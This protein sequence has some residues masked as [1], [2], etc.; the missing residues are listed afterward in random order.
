MDRRHTLKWYNCEQ[1]WRTENETC[2]LFT[3][4][5]PAGKQA[6]GSQLCGSISLN[7]SGSIESVNHGFHI[8]NA[9]IPSLQIWLMSLS[10]HHIAHQLQLWIREGEW[11]QKHQPGTR[12]CSSLKHMVRMHILH[13]APRLSTST[14]YCFSCS[15]LSISPWA[16]LFLWWFGFWVFSL[17]YRHCVYNTL[18]IFIN[19]VQVLIFSIRVIMYYYVHTIKLLSTQHYMW[20]NLTDSWQQCLFTRIG[21]PFTIPTVHMNHTSDR[22]NTY[23]GPTFV[24]I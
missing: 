12:G 23:S 11:V 21:S 10:L 22:W 4:L 14:K 3:K 15:V 2:C 16:V 8:S 9:M 17:F 7:N 20:M 18:S 5:L 19:A 1:I 24:I 13:Y 6:R